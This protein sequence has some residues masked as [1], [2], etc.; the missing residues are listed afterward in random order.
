MSV[1]SVGRA[2]APGDGDAG[3]KAARADGAVN[4]TSMN[5]ALTPQKRL[6][7][8]LWIGL[9]LLLEYNIIK[10]QKAMLPQSYHEEVVANKFIFSTQWLNVVVHLAVD[11]TTLFYLNALHPRWGVRRPSDQSGSAELIV[12]A[13]VPLLARHLLKLTHRF[14]PINACILGAKWWCHHGYTLKQTLLMSLSPAFFAITFYEFSVGG[15]ALMSVLNTVYTVGV[16]YS[17]REAYNCSTDLQAQFLQSVGGEYI[18]EKFLTY[19]VPIA[20]L[21]PFVFDDVQ[22]RP[23]VSR[24]LEA[25]ARLNGRVLLGATPRARARDGIDFP[26]MHTDVFFQQLLF[27]VDFIVHAAAAFVAAASAANGAS[28]LLVV[29]AAVAQATAAR[30]VL[31]RLSASTRWRDALRADGNGAAVAATRWIVSFTFACTA[32]ATT[33]A[34]KTWSTGAEANFDAA[35]SSRTWAAAFAAVA[36][37]M[38]ACA[39]GVGAFAASVGA[40][41]DVA[42]CIAGRAVIDPAAGFDASAAKLVFVGSYACALHLNDAL[43]FARRAAAWRPGVTRAREPVAANTDHWRPEDFVIDPVGFEVRAA[44]GLRTE[45]RRR[46]KPMAC[47]A[48]AEHAPRVDE[49][50]TCRATGCRRPVDFRSPMSAGVGLC[51]EHLTSVG[52]FECEPLNRPALFCLMCRRVHEAPRCLRSSAPPHPDC[53]RSRASRRPSLRRAVTP[54]ARGEKSR[55]PSLDGLGRDETAATTFWYKTEEGP[56]AAVDRVR[57]V[58]DD[59]ASEHPGMLRAEVSARP[60]CTLVT[61]DMVH[62][63]HAPSEAQ[64]STSEDP[65]DRWDQE[66]NQRADSLA[67]VATRRGLTGTLRFRAVDPKSGTGCTMQAVFT[68]DGVVPKFEDVSPGV[69]EGVSS[70]SRSEAHSRASSVRMPVLRSDVRDAVMLPVPP[71]EYEYILR[72]GATF[73]PIVSS[74]RLDV[75][76]ATYVIVHVEPTRAEGLGFFE[77]V[78]TAGVADAAVEGDLPPPALPVFLTPDPA[79][80][81]ELS[82]DKAAGG[83][84]L[85]HAPMLF[86]MSG[87]LS[88]DDAYAAEFAGRLSR[89]EIVFHAACSCASEGWSVALNRVL[90]TN[91]LDSAWERNASREV[92]QPMSEGP[93]TTTD[94]GRSNFED[95]STPSHSNLGGSDDSRFAMRLTTTAGIT[96]L[97]HSACSSGD[98]ATVHVAIAMAIRYRGVANVD[99][100]ITTDVGGAREGWT[101]LHASAAAIATKA[102]KE[103]ENDGVF[104][105]LVGD[106]VRGVMPVSL[107][108]SKAAEA[109]IVALSVS[110]DPLAWVSGSGSSARESPMAIASRLGPAKGV[111]YRR[112]GSRRAA[113]EM[114]ATNSVVVDALARAVVLAMRALRLSRD[115][116]ARSFDVDPQ[117]VGGFV[118]DCDGA[119]ANDAAHASAAATLVALEYDGSSRATIAAALLSSGSSH[120]HGAFMRRD[121]DD[122]RGEIG[123]DE[124]RAWVLAGASPHGFPPASAAE[125]RSNRLGMAAVATVWAFDAIL[126]LAVGDGAG[127]LAAGAASALTATAGLAA[128]TKHRRLYLC[129]HLRANAIARLAA[130]VVV[131]AAASVEPA[132]WTSAA[133]RVVGCVAQAWAAPAGKAADA[134]IVGAHA[135][136][137][138][139][140]RWIAAI[141]AGTVVAASVADERRA[142]RA[143]ERLSKAV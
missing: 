111:R 48:S 114:A 34:M 65:D 96:A 83:A 78:P 110:S 117:I 63:A 22:R 64:S 12:P 77:L 139:A 84:C 8:R 125:T 69:S 89:E 112:F 32:A 53:S 107:S 70:A 31:T 2:K 46:F 119:V 99:A 124:A 103:V 113:R 66:V 122:V 87:A 81:D 10:K 7:Y 128:E 126:A 94:S 88:P 16:S 49:K 13:S 40:A 138:G 101:P 105:N 118:E 104:G 36:A 92:P 11:L 56:V 86:N 27:T 72:R 4:C 129:H 43:T 3:R 109:A 134:V 35:A 115:V 123:L 133:L 47:D 116:A 17:N 106:V 15:L 62:R 73:L 76:G 20:F 60:G 59:Y 38:H 21:T 95:E 45:D 18:Q 9:V 121:A 98:A 75:T 93:D 141:A 97:L 23:G 6:A 24:A 14:P 100:L 51:A 137:V 44:K 135:A 130:F 80:A 120:Y 25:W 26:P 61:V 50:S 41:L 54:A 71:S 108:A 82:R 143:R 19:G 91:I 52:S 127:A 42:V 57:R 131:V 132:G 74:E 28:F 142:R 37:A 90:E 55:D 140:P 85:E 30:A 67:R 1:K 58:V 29:A 68:G 79:L 33:F 39:P 136:A 102:R 5:R